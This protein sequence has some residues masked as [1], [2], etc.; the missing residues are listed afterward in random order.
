MVM[1]RNTAWLKN[2]FREIKNSIERYLAIMAIIALG[3]GFFA[4]LKITKTAMIK[5][6]DTYVDDQKMYDYQL[7]STLGLTED[8]VKFFSAEKDIVAEGSISCDFI[9]HIGSEKG[10][11]LRAHSITQ[12]INHLN[13]RYGRLAK[14]GNECVLDS[15]FFSEDSIGSKIRIDSS[16]NEDTMD[17]F[18]YDEYTVVGIAD[19]VNYLNY[20]RGTTALAG[21]QVYAFIYIPKSGF[22]SDYYTEI[23]IRLSD[24]N[25]VYSQEYNDLVS[26]KENELKELL[27]QRGNIRYQSIIDEARKKVSDAQEEYDDAYEKYL[28]EKKDVE[29]EL[30]QALEELEKAEKEIKAQEKKLRYAEKRIAKGEKEYSKSLKEWQRAYK[31]YERR[32]TET[33]AELESRQNE[34]D[35]GRSS[36]VSTMEQIE[37]SGLLDQ[38][39]QLSETIIT[40][41]NVLSRIDDSESQ[42]YMMVQSQLEQAR[43]AVEEIEATGI[44]QQYFELEKAL[45]EIETGQKELEQ[46]RQEAIRSFADA[47]A[48]LADSKSK[49]VLAKKEIEKNKKDILAGWNAFEKGK[50]EYE[51]GVAEYKD[52]KRKAEEAFAKAEKELE[53]AQKDIEEAWKEIDDIPI[54]KV[55]VLNRN[56]NVGYTAFENDSSIVE[57]IARVLP[58][59]FFMVA[60]LVCLTTMSRMVDEQRTQIGTLKALGYSDG[61]IAGKYI[62]YSGSAATIGCIIGFFMGTKFFP[63][64]IWKAYSMIYEFSSIEY[65]FDVSLAIVSL[66]VSL[67]CSAGVTFISCK[68]ELLQMPAQ[69]IRPKAPK[70][71]KR[72]LLEYIPPLWNRIGFLYKV[73]IRNI[74]R[75]KRRFFMTVLGIAG[76]MSLIVAALGIGDSIRNIVN[77][78][79]D[80]ILVYDYSIS[81]NKAQSQKDREDFL[82][83]YSDILTE[84]IYVSMDEGEVLG[85]NQIK[86][87]TIVATDDP[88]ITRV[89]KL[90]LDGQFI[91]YPLF[92]QCVIN[93]KLARELG[94]TAGNT[95]SIRKN[96]LDPIDIE[97]GGVF[98]NYV[99]NYLFLTGETYESLFGEKVQYTS[100]YATT[101]IEDLYWVSALLSERKDVSAVTVLNDMRIMVDNMM[102]SLDYII[103]LVIICACALGFI[104]IYNLNNINITERTREVATIKVLGFYERETK[105]YVFRETI[106]ITIIAIISGL[107]LGNLLHGFVMDK[108]NVEAVSFRE[109]IFASSYVIAALITLMITLLV[110]LILSKKIDKINMAESLKSVE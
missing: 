82:K 86:K 88:D 77:D 31:D 67:L 54:P 38:H 110:N 101:D 13:M 19:S 5:N 58:F 35:Q 102:K 100:A 85:K 55:Y 24:Y 10:V 49:L 47:E 4:G 1:I 64:A 48:Q 12:K 68:T 26:Q 56:H 61:A 51:K 39:K 6:L 104:V 60:V 98:E 93:D 3:V 33:L 23:Y 87:V 91:P 7:I 53:Q 81:F 94:L 71:G 45:E 89:I 72:V 20:D 34:L 74:L 32:R 90:Y 97:V 70:P 99:G 11:V 83:E 50:V 46:G 75:Y 57:G 16:N 37:N 36:V 69:L 109:Q 40:L 84:C 28:E 8:D 17:L 15:R 105:S 107:G 73:S 92:G 65:V 30:N 43:V 2:N 80:T 103:W 108:I 63:I 96:G 79:Y 29:E 78:Q 76:C 95:I 14:A 27:E 44:L 66:I 25:E 62:F 42:E 21:G 52:A 41:E 22:R 106:M 18:A 59:F 9:A